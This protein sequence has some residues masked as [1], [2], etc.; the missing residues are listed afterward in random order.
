MK[1]A[2]LLRIGLQIVT[3]LYSYLQKTTG[4]IC[5]S[6]PSE[7]GKFYSSLGVT[8][9]FLHCFNRFPGN[10]ILIISQQR[11]WHEAW[12]S[13]LLYLTETHQQQHSNSLTWLIKESVS[14]FFHCVF[15][16]IALS[17]LN[18]LF[19]GYRNWKL[20][21]NLVLLSGLY[22]KENGINLMM[23]QHLLQ[24]KY[25]KKIL[26]TI[27]LGIWWFIRDVE[28]MHSLQHPCLMVLTLSVY[29]CDC[30]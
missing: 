8:D 3:Y 10:P 14:S 30:I 4:N 16:C 15:S 27:K 12:E 1:L 20:W 22:T 5:I 6:K 19:T 2:C 26:F 18:L 17:W 23:Q 21:H 9:G 13:Q 25:L 29:I 24:L 7:F 28:A 11:R